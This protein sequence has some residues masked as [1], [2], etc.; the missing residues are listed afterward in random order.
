MDTCAM[1]QYC[2]LCIL[3]SVHSVCTVTRC[4][5]PS[6]TRDG[7]AC[8]IN[9]CQNERVHRDIVAIRIVPQKDG[10]TRGHGFKPW[11]MCPSLCMPI[12]DMYNKRV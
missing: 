2:T 6:G 12:W 8:F 10:T 7:D 11:R 3:Y 9:V 4:M 5:C 1:V